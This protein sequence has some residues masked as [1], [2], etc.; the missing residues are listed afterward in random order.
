[1]PVLRMWHF[2]QSEVTV[3]RRCRGPKLDP[4]N[5]IVNLGEH[6]E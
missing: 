1:M 6:S 4:I 5:K 3:G 2:I